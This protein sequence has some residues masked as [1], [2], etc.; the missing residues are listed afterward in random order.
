LHICILIISGKLGVAGHHYSARD[1]GIALRD[2]GISVSYVV[3]ALN[4]NVESK[5]LENVSDVSYVDLCGGLPQRLFELRKV[6]SVRKFD[7]YFSF[8]EIGCRLLALLKPLFIRRFVAVKPGGVNSASWTSHFPHM[9]CF[10][11]ENLL[12][13]QK[14]PKYQKVKLHHIP[15]RVVAVSESYE[16]E[17]E[18]RNK[19]GLSL[20]DRILFAIARINLG[21]SHNSGKRIVFESAL[22]LYRRFKAID[23]RF[24][25]VC[26][27]TPK[28]QSAL[29]W[30]IA[31]CRDVEGAFVVTDPYYASRAS[32]LMGL[33]EALVAMGRTVMEGLSTGNVVFVPQM[34]DASTVMVTEQTF[35][36]LLQSNFTH[37][38]DF[39][40]LTLLTENDSQIEQ[41]A[42]DRDCCLHLSEVSK[43]LFDNKLSAFAAS[44]EYK[45]IIEDVKDAPLR[46]DVIL[47]CFSFFRFVGIMLLGHWNRI[48]RV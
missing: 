24:K 19:L 21:D 38:A 42:S 4:G 47:F 16:L 39:E 25:L 1:I 34:G 18:L 10:S 23:R 13:F 37:R 43:H 35:G 5:P 8:D 9:V 14:L 48:C 15:N 41:Y 44:D 6:L 46:F 20:D 3:V 29:D 17:L 22:R 12:F 28:N 33:S 40:D 36:I 11:L 2:V 27:G 30:L 45:V 32:S 31:K 26:I 7:A